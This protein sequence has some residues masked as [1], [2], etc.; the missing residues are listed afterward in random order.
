MTKT[1]IFDGSEYVYHGQYRG[2]NRKSMRSKTA[3][4]EAKRLHARGY[5]VR[6]IRHKLIG[7]GANVFVVWRRKKK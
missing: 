5:N 4:A 2:K 7:S 1:R 6:I 3:N